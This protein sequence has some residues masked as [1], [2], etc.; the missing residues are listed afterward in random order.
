MKNQHLN[1]YDIQQFTFDS[2]ECKSEII[3]HISSCE[4]CKMRV[5]SY[6]SLS[7]TIK[8]QQEPIFG[9]NLSDQV[10]K[11]LKSNEKKNSI[12]S[13]LIYFLI[14]LSITVVLFSLCYFKDIFIDLFKSTSVIS[15]SFILSITIL[16][17]LAMI[18]DIL[19]SYNR[20]INI[21]NY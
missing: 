14:T 16:I 7:N 13:Y 20:K 15:M 10:I 2:S 3:E 19:R 21:L 12:Y 6:L 9:F 5:E 1:D 11:Q 8:N 18:F 17:S 4:T